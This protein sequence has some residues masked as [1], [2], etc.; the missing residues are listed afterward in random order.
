[1]EPHLTLAQPYVQTVSFKEKEWAASYGVKESIIQISVG[2]ED[3]EELKSAFKVALE[4]ADRR[5][6]SKL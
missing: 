1:L 3:R 4:A 5:K 6:K 2:L